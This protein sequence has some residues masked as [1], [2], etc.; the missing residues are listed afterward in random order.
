M[1]S[2]PSA[3]NSLSPLK[4]AGIGVQEAPSTEVPQGG[5]FARVSSVQALLGRTRDMKN[6]LRLKPFDTSTEEGRSQ[7]RYRRAALT[8]LASVAARAVTVC[9]SLL[10]VRLTIHYLGTER[11]G[12]WMTVTSVV[13]LLTF[14]DL[15]I[16]NGLL[17]ALADAHGRDD[18][19]AAHRYV[20]S[21]FF[22][23]LGIATLLLAIFG[24]VY[25]FIPWARLFNVASPLA[26]REAGPAVFVFLA[27]FLVNMPLDV[28]QRVQT[29]RQKGFATSIWTIVGS[30]A[31]LGCLIL[32]MNRQGGLP[33]L[34]LAILGGQ[35]LGVLGNWAQEFGVAHPE[36]FPSP[37]YWDL[38]SA[39]MILGTGIMFF[40]LQVCGALSVP[41]DNIIITQVLGPE[42]VTQYA[43]PIRPFILLTSVAS[44]FVMPLWPAYGEAL[45]RG[46]SKWVKST[47]RHSISYSVLVFG[48]VCLGLAV[49]GKFIIRVWVGPAV[50]P[51]SPLLFGMFLYTLGIVLYNASAML[52]YGM[53]KLKFLV[54]VGMVQAFTGVAVKI[55]MARVSGITGVTWGNMILV[56]LGTGAT[57]LYAR[58]SLAGVKVP[59]SSNLK[60]GVSGAPGEETSN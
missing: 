56:V 11:Y 53:N 45:A 20:S 47:F 29:G 46:D 39:R 38:A 17:N 18:M 22:V 51:T 49:F 50:H 54:A 14:A 7:E 43:V 15:G 26:V 41:L 16:G 31:G 2:D 30:L 36:L 13:S 59:L 23:L 33:W 9:T 19:K 48:P 42:A 25:S 52:L 1:P 60:L 5:S 8:T 57:L 34:I 28:V 37:G 21:A 27:C 6:L 10:T 40:L 4:P 32:V 55:L 24:C 58:S 3:K 44:M 35:I 12:L